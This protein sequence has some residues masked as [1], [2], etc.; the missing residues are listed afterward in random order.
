MAARIYIG[1]SG[2]SYPH[3][4]GTFYPTELKAK[5]E[6]KYY[7]AHFDTVE[8][9]NSFYRLPTYENFLRWKMTST[10]NFIFS[11]KANRFITHMKKLK[12]PEEPLERMLGN[13]KGLG[14]K[15]GPILFQFPPSWKKNVERF[16]S[17]LSKLPKSRRYV[18]EFREH[19]W[20]NNDIITL[21][22]KHNC[23]F[24]IYELAGHV[25]PTIVTADFVYV[26]LHGPGD[27]YQGS[28]KRQ[29]LKKWAGLCKKW[30]VSGMDVYVYFD[31][32]QF[33]YAAKNA[34]RLKDLCR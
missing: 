9:N 33:G 21:L 5:D 16:E 23:A 14:K 18:F 8:L 13:F 25:S 27:K 32:D 34:L 30:Q 10:R 6:F 26:R 12:D 31:N 17:F 1:T 2:W 22:R 3:W 28:Y 15:L 20:Y 11:V 29:A 19:S 7:Q 24:C 4:R